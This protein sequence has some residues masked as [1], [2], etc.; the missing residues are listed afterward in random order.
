MHR[1]IASIIW[2]LR[3]SMPSMSES[4][5]EQYAR[6]MQAEAVKYGWD[7]FTYVSLITFESGGNAGALGDCDSSGKNCKAIGLG[8][9]WAMFIGACRDDP[10]PNDSPGAS[11]LDVRQSLMDGTY[12]LKVLARQL[13]RQRAWCKAQTGKALLWNT[14]ASQAGINH[15]RFK[16][17]K[18]GMRKGKRGWKR[19]HLGLLTRK[20]LQRVINHRHMLIRKLSQ[21]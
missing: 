2:A 10:N 6:T 4:T 19:I 1:A 7:P 14:L 12:N 17:V 3:I 9:I 5:A 8:Q 13:A 15:P 21:R 11:C 18:C 20:T 16:D